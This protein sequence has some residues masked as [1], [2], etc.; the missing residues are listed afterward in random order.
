[1]PRLYKVHVI[2]ALAADRAARIPGS[3]VEIREILKQRADKA[4]ELIDKHSKGSS[5]RQRLLTL[6]NE[7]LAHRD[8][9]PVTGTNATD[10]EVEVFYQD[11]SKLMSLLLSL[12]MAHHYDPE[13][14]AQGLPFSCEVFLGRGC[15]GAGLKAI[16]IIENPPRSRSQSPEAAEPA[17]ENLLCS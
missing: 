14:T 1:M 9:A 15:V 12:V 4:I 7:R 6:R 17:K 16:R 13:D 2:N 5:A 8:I 10:D 3:E 11:M